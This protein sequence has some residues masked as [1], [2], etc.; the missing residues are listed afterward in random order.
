MHIFILFITLLISVYTDIRSRKILNKVTLPAILIGLIYHSIISGFNGFTFSGLGL[1]VGIGLLFI[2]FA[3]GG[4]GAGDV[5]LMGAIGALMGSS[6][7]FTTFLY[8]AIIGGL[9]SLYIMIRRK[10][11]LSFF[12]RAMFSAVLLKETKGSVNILEKRDLAPSFPYGVAI[13]LGALCAY[14]FG[15]IL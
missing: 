6:F 5:K 9:I 8:T 3:M 14:L 7:V 4:M 11:L 10:E 12:K 1:L 15:G 13:A 2:P